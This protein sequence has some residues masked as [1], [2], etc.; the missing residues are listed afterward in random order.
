MTGRNV[1]G[2]IDGLTGVGVGVPAGG[3]VPETGA[4]V[5]ATGTTGDGEVA[6]TVVVGCITEPDVVGSSVVEGLVDGCRRRASTGFGY[7]QSVLEMSSE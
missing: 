3:L 7:G 5:G 1:A 6:G 4:A 2:C